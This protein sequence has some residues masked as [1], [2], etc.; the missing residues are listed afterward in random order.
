M[1]NFQSASG[2]FTPSTTRQAAS[3]ARDWTYIETWLN[4]KSSLSRRSL[5]ALFERNAETLQTLLA[6]AAYNESVDEEKA[7]FFEMEVAA[8]KDMNDSENSLRH[9]DQSSLRGDLLYTI[10]EELPKEGQIALAGMADMATSAGIAFPEPQT[11]G[12]R[13]VEIQSEIFEMQQLVSR[14][15]LLGRHINDEV[16]KAEA[17][18]KHI[19]SESFKSSS[20]WAKGN[21]ETQKQIKNLDARLASLQTNNRTSVASTNS[22]HPKLEDLAEAEHSYMDLLQKKKELDIDMS[23]FEGLPAD[24]SQARK[25][26][27]EIRRQLR[28]ITSRRDAVFEGLVERESPVKARRR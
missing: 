13:F 22:A 11:L 26:V 23:R 15:E 6:L 1:A 7:L 28:D 19:S 3:S 27:D 4:N 2:F 14:V 21:L 24:I 10:E 12:K 25:E 9:G 17:T 16:V 20:T 18:L 8:L 5:P